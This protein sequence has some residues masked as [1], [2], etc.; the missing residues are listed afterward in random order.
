M[1]VTLLQL[2]YDRRLPQVSSILQQHYKLLLERSPGVKEWM[3][4]SPMVAYQRPANLRDLLVR[5]QLPPVDRRRGAGRGP[6]LGFRKC[7][8]T[9]C[10]CCIYC[11]ESRTHSSSA[12][13]ETWDIKQSI[14]CEDSSVLYAV[15]C[16]HQGG[17]C[18]DCP[19]YVGMVGTTRAC[20]ERCT[21]HRGAVRNNHDT[22]VGEH[23]NLPGHSLDD[24][25]FLAF[26]KVRNQDPFVLEAREHYWIQKYG[27]MDR[28]LNRRM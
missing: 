4:R 17:R 12:T 26:E 22:A 18:Q 1:E 8:K 16:R 3:A 15:T 2:P 27:T 5:A 19:Q 7:G 24:F 6:H 28:G 10:L 21:E 11:E 13:Q 23:F 25:S 20:R 14:S 9:N